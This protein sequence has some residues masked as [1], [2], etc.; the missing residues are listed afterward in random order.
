MK[1][2]LA[3]LLTTGA[4]SAAETNQPPDRP[5][6]TIRASLSIFLLRSNEFLYTNNVVVYDPPAKPGDAPTTI[7]C[8]WLTAKRGANGKFE[9][10]IAHERVKIDQGNN[11]ARGNLA[12]YSG[13]DETVTLTGAFGS[14]GSNDFTLPALFSPQ[15]TNFGTKIVYDRL[16][17]RLSITDPITIIP[18]AS[19]SKGEG[20]N[21]NSA[22]TNKSRGPLLPFSNPK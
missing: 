16:N 1:A 12:V 13:I 6:L 2:L 9:T 15:G 17:D 3:L 22:A 11:H 5:A 8:G 4:V 20:G 7:T 19:L 10:I 14:D 21:T 18:Q